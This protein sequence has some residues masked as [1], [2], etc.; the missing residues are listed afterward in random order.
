[1][2]PRVLDVAL[3][4]PFKSFIF[5]DS[6]KEPTFITDKNQLAKTMEKFTETWNEERDQFL[7]SLFPEPLRKSNA[8]GKGKAV[9][10]PLNL[11]TT[12]FR[13]SSGQEGC[14]SAGGAIP[15]PSVLAHSCQRP[16]A[17]KENR[18]NTDPDGL[19][20]LSTHFY[21]RPWLL[22]CQDLSFDQKASDVARMVVQECGENPDE[23]TA[24]RMGGLRFE[25]VRCSEPK[26]GRCVMKWDVAVSSSCAHVSLF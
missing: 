14:P 4:E 11:A 7:L 22:H 19:W 18:R 21:T 20:K 26:L 3:S 25:C 9:P 16:L 5:D 17:R 15:Y 12:F 24:E 10:S 8:K 2:L 23:A 1:M 13:C 6:D